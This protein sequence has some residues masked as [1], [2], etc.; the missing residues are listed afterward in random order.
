MTNRGGHSY[1]SCAAVLVIWRRP[2]PLGGR[3]PAPI[4]LGLGCQSSVG[5]IYCVTI[6]SKCHQDQSNFSANCISS[7]FNATRLMFFFFFFF[8]KMVFLSQWC[9][10]ERKGGPRFCFREENERIS[11]CRSSEGVVLKW[12]QIKRGN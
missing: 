11:D 8:Y 2:A 5:L 3:G 7:P 10:D 1:Q 9:G 4:K 6:S 12:Q